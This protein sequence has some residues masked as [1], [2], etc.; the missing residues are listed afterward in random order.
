[1]I[2]LN[3]SVRRFL[4][5]ALEEDIGAG[6]ITT[7]A[8]VRKGGVSVSVI[9]G[10]DDFVLAG[11]PFAKEVFNLLD[12]GIAFDNRLSEG[13]H[14]RK[15]DIIAEL[16]G[17]TGR[18]LMGERLALNILQRL[19]GIATLTGRFVERIKDTGAFIVDTRKTTPNMRSLE[20]YAVLTGGGRN[21]RFALY[22]GIL[23]KENHI[24]A[25]GGIRNAVRGVK[26]KMHFL[27]KIEIEVRDIGELREA[28]SEGVDVVML[29]NM[30]VDMMKEAVM[31]VRS[32]SPD[33]LIEASGSVNLDN[34]RDIA[35]TGVD[36]ISVGALTHS[37]PAV[38]ISMKIL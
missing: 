34:V 6:D 10:K 17:D 16:R 27:M 9:T 3:E 26:Q 23:I 29:D 20:R 13:A 31:V 36:F 24:K 4:L 11:T 2:L 15:G 38:D 5:Q 21:H 8:T 18:L 19:S 22:D 28:V 25:A 12:P 7:E 35:L 37:A 1:M 32:E 33:T 30:T 14:V